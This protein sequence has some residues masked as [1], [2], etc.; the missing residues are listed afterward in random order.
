[1]SMELRQ[2]TEIEVRVGPFLDVSDGFT[3][4]TGIALSTADEA[5]LLKADGAATVDLS[6]ATWTAVTGADGW[7]DLTLTTSHTDTVGE[8][9]V[10]VQDDSV[11]LPVF[12]RFQVLPAAAY[13]MKYG[14]LAAE[15]GTAQSGTASSIR[16]ATTASITADAYN[17]RT[18]K[19]T[20]GTGAGQVRRVVDY[21]TDRDALVEPDWQT[22]PDSSTTYVIYDTP[23]SADST[24]PEVDAVL[25]EGG[26]AT[27]AIVAALLPYF[28]LALRSDAAIA[29]DRS[30]ELSSLN[31]DEGS[32]AGDY[33]PT[34]EALEALRD[35]GDTS[36]VTGGGGTNPLVL[37]N[38]TI[39]TL[40]SQVSFTLTAGS[41]DDDAYNDCLIVVTDQGTGSQ[42][43]LGLIADYTGSSKTVA[44][45]TDPGIFTIATGDTVDIIAA[46]PLLRVL[47]AVLAGKLSGGGTS[48]ETIRDYQ[49][50]KDRVVATVDASGNRSAIGTLDVS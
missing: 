43:C 18:I 30:S 15:A 25:I 5:E 2:S 16:L 22:T 36:W 44:L 46:N 12:M 48:T 26:D 21:E 31:A 50:T 1:M 28:Q 49:D 13:D 39:A 27:N 29:S 42:K 34:T 24:L 38:T 19:L 47:G 9:V 35:R 20:G 3:P 40:A 8:L 32:G 41:A 7:Y 17:G 10:V 45:Q 4:E 14:T 6:G 23:P 33:A 11:C 37:Q